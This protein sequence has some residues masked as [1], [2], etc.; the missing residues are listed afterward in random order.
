[1]KQAISAPQKEASL[2][3]PSA[4]AGIAMA[5][6]VQ[7][8]IDESPRQLTQQGKMA[9]WQQA[10]TAS[11][12]M[13]GHV[14]Q[15]WLI[16]DESGLFV[17]F[18]WALLANGAWVVMRAD[19]IPQHWNR[20][21]NGEQGEWFFFEPVPAED[22][23]DLEDEPPPAQY[24]QDLMEHAIYVP[25]DDRQDR[26]YIG[27]AVAYTY[28]LS[29]CTAI[30]LYHSRT[31][32]S[33]LR[34]ADALTEPAQVQQ[35]VEDYIRQVIEGSDGDFS[36]EDIEVTIYATNGPENRE[37]SFEKIA[38][39]LRAIN[40]DQNVIDMF[41]RA[42]VAEGMQREYH[43]VMGGGLAPGYVDPG[44]GMS[45]FEY[46]LQ[47]IVD[48]DIGDGMIY[49]ATF[50]QVINAAWA[51]SS[52]DAREL[53]GA[54][55][56]SAGEAAAHRGLQTEAQILQNILDGVPYPREPDAEQEVPIDEAEY[57]RRRAEAGGDHL[58][59]WA[60]M[61]ELEDQI[62]AD[63]RQEALG[64]RDRLDGESKRS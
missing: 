55:I 34:H 18:A 57:N 63:L 13:P 36:L 47:H 43:I 4:R 61:S 33:Y 6:P 27:Q 12:A 19:Q 25:Q 56:A 1:M 14:V 64:R 60:E 62:R 3:R 44:H 23:Q 5:H 8:R 40:V 52:G 28:N 16:E 29:T 30:S 48:D 31:G 53:F 38:A 54:L 58:T 24:V 9:Q 17:N 11:E 46:T 51:Y 45:T 59:N 2:Q 32:L 21:Y 10:P 39:G 26:Y 37:S 20:E 35:S 41:D 15:R 50:L 7:R 22:A 49:G 42:H